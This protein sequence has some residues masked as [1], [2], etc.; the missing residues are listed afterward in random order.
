MPSYLLRRCLLLASL[1]YFTGSAALAQG[2]V[3]LPS[4][5]YAS[6]TDVVLTAQTLTVEDLVS[7]IGPSVEDA[8]L[9][10]LANGRKAVVFG[11]RG[12][13]DAFGYGQWNVRYAVQWHDACGRLLAQGSSSIDGFALYPNEYRTV[14]VVAFQKDAVRATLR[15]YLD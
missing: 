8:Q 1:F 9:V 5:G 10:S 11:V 13:P 6:C 3:S 4:A 12:L 2:F 7:S 15:V 14:E